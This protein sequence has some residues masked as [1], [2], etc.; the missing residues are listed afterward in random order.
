MCTYSS[1]VEF[2]L[3][4]HPCVTM[5]HLVK[6]SFSH[7]VWKTTTGA[8]CSQTSVLVVPFLLMFGWCLWW[9]YATR[10]KMR[11]YWQ[12]SSIFDMN[13]C[14][15]MGVIVQTFHQCPFVMHDWD[16]MYPS[17]CMMNW[18]ELYNNGYKTSKDVPLSSRSSAPIC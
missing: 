4:Q 7:L 15:W 18:F 14:I 12:K 13:C 2:K 9:W 10:A 16:I 11:V 17:Q 6:I 8:K 3:N 5:T 1:N